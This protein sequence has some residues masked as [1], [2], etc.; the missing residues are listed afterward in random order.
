MVVMLNRKAS[1]G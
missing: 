1:D